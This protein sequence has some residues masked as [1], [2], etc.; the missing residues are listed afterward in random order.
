MKL[1]YTICVSGAASGLTVEP[2]KHLAER[3]GAAIAKR[4]HVLT[5]GAT[6]GL[7][8]YAAKGAKKAGG[9]SIGFSPAAS[10]REHLRK[11]RLP[12]EYFDFVSYTGLAYVGRDAFLIQS[13]DAIIT[14]GG[15]F[16]SLHEFVTAL[17][18]HKPVGVLTETG[19][20]ADVVSP[21]MRVLEPPKGH[22][23]VYDENPENLVTRIVAL[24][25]DEYADVNKDLMRNQHW[26]LK[27]NG[28]KRT[29]HESG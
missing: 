1:Q 12:R 24:L 5:T 15:R 6:I 3:L 8:F 25:D 16:G 27:D 13:S 18:A 10:V 17:E 28:Q 14:L 21:L 26:F 9:L 22:M 7:P 4:G 29:E 19:G 23:V 11:Y 2:A 20:A